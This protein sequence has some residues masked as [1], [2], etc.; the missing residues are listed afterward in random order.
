MN[1]QAEQLLEFFASE[2]RDLLDQDIG[3][4]FTYMLSYDA[5][6]HAIKTAI[7]FADSIEDDQ[8]DERP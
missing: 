7:R 2:T 5:D 4:S 8:G 3:V 6:Q 1:A